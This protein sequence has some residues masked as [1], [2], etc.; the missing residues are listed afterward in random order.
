MDQKLQALLK[1]HG[2]LTKT[3]S[4]KELEDLREYLEQQDTNIDTSRHL[5]YRNMQEYLRTYQRQEDTCYD[6]A[7]AMLCDK[8]YVLTLLNYPWRSI[9]APYIIKYRLE[10]GV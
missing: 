6:R 2:P 4:K 1:E 8:D 5:L 3:W 7:L 9:L 10:C